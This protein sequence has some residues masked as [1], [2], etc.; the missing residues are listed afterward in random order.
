MM[1]DTLSVDA[2]S[3]LEKLVNQLACE[4]WAVCDGFLN[5]PE[6]QA[7]VAEVHD[8][9]NSFHQAHVGRG[10]DRELHA[11]I[12]QDHVHWLD[13]GQLTVAQ[14]TYWQQMERLRLALNQH[15]FLGLFDY[16]AHLSVYPKGAFYKRHL[17]QFR[18]VGLRMVSCI[19]YLSDNWTQAD[20]GQL[21][22]YLNGEAID[23]YCDI[24]PIAGRLVMFLSADFYHEVL[25]AHRE[26]LSLTGWF[27]R[28]A[29]VLV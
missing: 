2:H 11:E 10:Q 4:G 5:A 15:L 12:R 20:G 6:V 23:H 29:K 21:R 26:R 7:L 19:L 17:D 28:R 18:G 13:S 22:L 8:L 27:R 14:Q 24:L 3:P 25:P 9:R 1:N 16:E